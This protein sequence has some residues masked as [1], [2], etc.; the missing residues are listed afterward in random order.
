MR[1]NTGAITEFRAASGFVE[2]HFGDG[3]DGGASGAPACAR[4]SARPRAILS[5]AASGSLRYQRGL[6]NPAREV[7]I[8]G[9]GIAR[10]RLLP[11]ELHHTRNVVL[12]ETEADARSVE[13]VADAAGGADGIVSTCGD[14]VLSVTVA[15]CMPI[16]LHDSRTGAFGLL[17]SGWKGTGILGTAIGLMVERLDSHP[18]DIS[19]LLGPHIGSCCYRVDAARAEI[20]SKEFGEASVIVEKDEG[21]TERFFL[22]LERANRGIAASWGLASVKTIAMCTSCTPGLGSFRR[23]GAS[24]FS[25]MMALCGYFFTEKT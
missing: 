11:L 21:G 15:D 8:E 7:F 10:D 22:D 18:E 17:H 12:V 5:T 24:S 19:V 2:F 4:I 6:P 9:L 14:Y 23:E 20:F 3:P 25:R 13:S 1:N 16:W